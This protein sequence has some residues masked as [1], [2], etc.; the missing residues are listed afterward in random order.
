MQRRSATK[1]TRA[2]LADTP[3]LES[4]PRLLM[5][6]NSPPLVPQNT[7]NQQLMISIS[8]FQTMMSNVIRRIQIIVEFYCPGAPF[9]M[10]FIYQEDDEAHYFFPKPY[11][12]N[13]DNYYVARAVFNKKVFYVFLNGT[14]DEKCHVTE[15]MEVTILGFKK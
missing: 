7:Y 4:R 14:T 9:W 12:V 11:R 5:E 1:V 15:S 13:G 2:N 10:N 6:A 3:S 8:E